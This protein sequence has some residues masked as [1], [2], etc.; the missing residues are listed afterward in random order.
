MCIRDSYS[1]SENAQRYFKKYQK[2]K[3]GRDFALARQAET[4]EELQYL[5]GQLDNLSKCTEDGELMELGEELR[6]LGYMKSK[7]SR[8]K[9]PKLP[10]S[11]PMHFIASD[12]TDIFVGKNNRQNDALTAKASGD[13]TWLHTKEIPGSHVILKS[14]SPS[15]TVL[16]EA[17][18]LAAWYS[19]ARGSANVPVDYTLRK[20]VKKPGGAKPGMVIYTTNHT[21]Y[22]TPEEGVVKSIRVATDT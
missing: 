19:K 17:C 3:A 5:E 14:A 12:G 20:F 4:L 7:Q 15:K 22:V 6:Q 16:Y 18:V 1:P 9:Q 21:A 10:P 13:D 2:A 8:K 11:K